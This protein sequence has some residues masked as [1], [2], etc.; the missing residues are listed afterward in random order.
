MR[1]I[2]FHLS[3]GDREAKDEEKSENTL[4]VEPQ[5]EFSIERNQIPRIKQ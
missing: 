5:D 2:F 1:K 4:E 3:T